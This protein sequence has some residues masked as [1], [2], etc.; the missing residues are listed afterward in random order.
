M[1]HIDVEAESDFQDRKIT[2]AVSRLGQS[3]YYWATRPLIDEF[4]RKTLE[5]IAQKSVLEIGCGSGNVAKVFH[6][7]C[8]SYVGIDLSERSI[9]KASLK[10][11]PGA[12]FRTADAHAL[13]FENGRFDVVVAN[14]VLHHMELEVALKEIARVL[15]PG[16]ILCTREPLGINPVFSAYRGV[17]PSERTAD[18]RPFGRSELNLMDRYFATREIK[19]FGFLSIASAFIRKPGFRDVLTR[20]DDALARTPAKFLFWQFYAFLNRR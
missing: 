6:M 20:L 18:E 16:G 11:L 8:E 2:G 15:K 17:T 3:K 13:P 14:S 7:V 9:E 12:E 10:N 19:Y 4:N 1:R 5:A